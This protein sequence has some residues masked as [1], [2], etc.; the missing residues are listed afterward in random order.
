[1]VDNDMTCLKIIKR[2]H[3]YSYINLTVQTFNRKNFS[4]GVLSTVLS[5]LLGV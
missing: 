3:N 2:I 1:M 4:K 5:P